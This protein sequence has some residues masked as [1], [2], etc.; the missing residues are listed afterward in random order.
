M[1]N[2]PAKIQPPNQTTA[3]LFLF[4]E[5]R[6]HWIL[7]MDIDIKRLILCA[8]SALQGDNIIYL[9]IYLIM[10][11]KAVW[12]PH[13]LHLSIG[14]Q[15]KELFSTPL[16]RA[17]GISDQKA[18]RTSCTLLAGNSFCV[19]EVRGGEEKGSSRLPPLH[20]QPINLTH[21]GVISMWMKKRPFSQP[22]PQGTNVSIHSSVC[23]LS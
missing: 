22:S 19:Q 10:Q 17:A 3:C 12:S 13:H 23:W 6:R 8:Y 9:S 15:F 1:D 7:L 2:W 20:S 21:W 5:G 11:W 4:W 18:G 16:G 14:P